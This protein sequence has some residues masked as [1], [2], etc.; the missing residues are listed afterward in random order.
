MRAVFWIS[1]D[2]ERWGRT[3]QDRHGNRR[4]PIPEDASEVDEVHWRRHL[5]SV[6]ADRERAAAK[7]REQWEQ[8]RP[9]PNAVLRPAQG[10]K[11]LMD[12]AAHDARKVRVDVAELAKHVDAYEQGDRV[13]VESSIR[14]DGENWAEVAHRMRVELVPAPIVAL[15]SDVVGTAN[16][17]L[18]SMHAA[19]RLTAAK[20]ARTAHAE[21]DA[22]PQ[23]D[24]P[25]PPAGFP[26]PEEWPDS[27]VTSDWTR[28]WTGGDS[29]LAN[30]LAQSF[31]TPAT[32]W[33]HHP[34]N[35]LR[36]LTN[37]LPSG[38]IVDV[39][40]V[41][42]VLGDGQTRVN[43]MSLGFDV[44][45]PTP[46]TGIMSKFRYELLPSDRPG[47][48]EQLEREIARCEALP[49][50]DVSFALYSRD[51]ELAEL[52]RER[53]SW[54]GPWDVSRV[55]RTTSRIVL[56]QPPHH[57]VA[58]EL[59]AIADFVNHCLSVHHRFTEDPDG[60]DSP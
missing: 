10:D 5:R 27:F 47:H 41:A 34:A 6:R 60:F 9:E 38:P 2:G 18:N 59:K 20:A 46:T 49:E 29:R 12:Y 25:S 45:L 52:Q 56:A 23:P 30:L 3:S 17:A 35:T 8:N 26:I 11:R 7:R 13:T 14:T 33:E 39:A 51:E 50:D 43:G 53:Q 15:A 48:L 40:A 19:A 57:R 24:T 22:D 42:D 32:E 4:T 36:A 28:A 1:E 16:R 44:T 55:V 54:T 31:G 21:A 58:S 37:Q